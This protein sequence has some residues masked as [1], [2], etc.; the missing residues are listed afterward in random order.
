MLGGVATEIDDVTITVAASS[1]AAWDAPNDDESGQ[2]AATSSSVDD[3]EN[4][5]S[6]A[7]TVDD[8]PTQE[9]KPQQ[10]QGVLDGRMDM[11]SQHEGES[12]HEEQRR[13][14][15]GD[16]CRICHDTSEE[17]LISPCHCSS[18]VHASC[19]RRWGETCSGQRNKCEICLA[20]YP[21]E[22][23]QEILSSP[24][25][26]VQGARRVRPHGRC[27]CECRD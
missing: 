23:S 25:A 21:E 5:A 4:A 20:T 18:F 16:V 10:G 13:P 14:Q 27:C 12:G 3:Y 9:E 6:T 24:R 22:L 17:E 19:L 1:V 7:L 8:E 2:D 26:A 15:P 11:V